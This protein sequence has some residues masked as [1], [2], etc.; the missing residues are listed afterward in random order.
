MTTIKAIVNGVSVS[1]I[2]GTISIS[3]VTNATFDNYYKDICQRVYDS[4]SDQLMTQFSF[5]LTKEAVYKIVSRTV[6][7]YLTEKIL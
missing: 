1:N 5:Y 6:K 7:N 4:L 3:I 2:N